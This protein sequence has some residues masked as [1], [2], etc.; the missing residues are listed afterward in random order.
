MIELQVLAAL[1]ALSRIEERVLVSLRTHGSLGTLA[2]GVALGL[3][4]VLANN[5]NVVLDRD[6]NLL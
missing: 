2:R 5:R 3:G 1:A 4:R 6:R